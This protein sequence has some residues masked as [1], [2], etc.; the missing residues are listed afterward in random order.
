MIMGYPVQQDSTPPRSLLNISTA[1]VAKSGP[2]FIFK[3]ST[4]TGPCSIYDSNT[5]SGNVAANLIAT[6]PTVTG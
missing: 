2:G 6:T 4:I 5:T 3:V 1:T